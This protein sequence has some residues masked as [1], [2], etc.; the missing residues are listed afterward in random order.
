MIAPRIAFKFLPTSFGLSNGQESKNMI[1]LCDGNLRTNHL[2]INVKVEEDHLVI[3]V[4]EDLGTN[5]LVLN[6]KI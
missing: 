1:S 5:H 6:V 2:V 3:N 4:E